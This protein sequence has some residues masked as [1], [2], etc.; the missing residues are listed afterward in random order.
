VLP[1]FTAVAQVY[2]HLMR[3]IPYRW[4]LVYVEQL[5]A[6]FEKR[7]Q[8]ALDLACGTGTFAL[9]LASKGYEVV[10]VDFSLDMLKEARRKAS[11]EDILLPFVQQDAVALAFKP[12]FD[13]VV[14][15][16]DSLNY[17][18]G[19]DRLARVFEGV[20]G[21]CLPGGTFLFDVN[22]IRALELELFTQNNL[23]TSDWLK[24]NWTSRYNP[25]TRI[26]TIQM[27]FKLS[28]D[29]KEYSFTETHQQMGY[30]LE[31]I[32]RM[33][34][35]AGFRILGIF[36]AYSPANANQLSTRAFFVAEKPKR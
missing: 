12:T 7:P 1:S 30:D 22:T 24:Y 26:A 28:R 11:E 18:I 19:A 14:S 16:F 23:S 3:S 21:A 8:A 6:K 13:L 34:T 32:E 29:G 4:W 36:D 31:E 2:D 5:L 35:E 27:A 20:Y 17:V 33:L 25:T 10:G 9:L 15:L